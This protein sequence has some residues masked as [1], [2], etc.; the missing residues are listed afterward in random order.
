[1]HG[2]LLLLAWSAP[3]L[4]LPFTRSRLAGMLL[5]LAALPALT[6]AIIVP[7]GTTLHVPWLLLGLTLHLDP[8][9]AVFLLF[10]SVM[11]LF[12]GLYGALG[13]TSEAH[14]GRFSVFFLLACA[15][16]LLLILAAD[17]VTFYV[18][19]ALMGLSATGLI[20]HR[21]SQ[22]ARR[23]ARIYLAWTLVGEM[24][25][26]SAVVLLAQELTSLRFADLTATTLPNAA[27]ALLLFGFGVK[28]AL[29]G[30]HFWL[31]LAYPTAPAVAT[32]VLSGPMISAG[33]LGWLR[34]L[35]PGSLAASEWGE[36]LLVIGIVGT[37]LG[38]LAGLLQRDPRS[39]LAYSSIAKMGLITSAFG[40]AL[41]QPGSA[42]SIV[43]ALVVFAM[44]HLML[45]GTLFLGIGEW[46]R[47]GR[48]PW[49]IATISL[50]AL[51]MI[52]APF[53]SG[54]GAKLMLSEAMNHTGFDLDLLFGFATAGTLLLMARLIWLIT[55]GSGSTASGFDPAS[56]AWLALAAIS[57]V[58]PLS[59]MPFPT[60]SAGIG[61]IASGLVAVAIYAM[62]RRRLRF[63][64]P[65]VPPGDLLYLAR[66][67]QRMWSGKP[68]RMTITLS[69]RALMF[70]EPCPTSSCTPG[71]LI[72]LSVCVFLLTIGLMPG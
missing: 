17:V 8:V 7:E 35:P 67:A 54:A 31:P 38:V 32:A 45:K 4:M 5:A 55:Q 22:R 19:F 10:S 24:A 44:H 68:G 66:T 11:W 50:L 52:G 59:L 12:A 42:P 23:A 49:L 2:I 33:L 3:L 9:G 47:N 20:L 60:A 48:S 41:A 64:P 30:L 39:V 16:N 18:G 28:L 53:T 21:R 15:G 25:L 62:V 46:Q 72:W 14:T 61:A 63:Q 13:S 26:F 65:S 6:A 69:P 58:L 70:A 29:P 1:M 51:A 27:A 56:L 36:G 43:A 40:V 57:I 34:F 71:R 37:T